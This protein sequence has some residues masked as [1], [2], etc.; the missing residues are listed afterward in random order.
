[1]ILYLDT[2]ALVKMYVEEVGSADVRNKSGQ[3]EGIATSRIAYAEARA[4]LARK[5]REGGLSGSDYRLVVEELD[6]DWANYFAVEV[7]DSLVKSAGRLAEKYALRGADAI[8]LA[9]AV[10]LA[11]EVGRSL[12]FACFD[13]QLSSA[14]RKERLRS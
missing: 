12:M 9:S 1:M 10:I 13:G 2:S 5:Y 8:H 14:A 4:A 7:S 6:Q 3:A 11:K